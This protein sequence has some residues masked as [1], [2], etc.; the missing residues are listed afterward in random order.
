MTAL[1]IA[2]S[3]VI[4]SVIGIWTEH[5]Q[6]MAKLR[7]RSGDAADAGVRA[8][9]DK[10]AEDVRSI[11]ETTMQYDISFDAALQRLE[12]RVGGLESRMREVEQTTQ[13]T[14]RSG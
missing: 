10:L 8:A 2:G 4:I 5:Q 1:I 13:V 12:T 6:K 11:R 9:I 7:F 3:V 14:G